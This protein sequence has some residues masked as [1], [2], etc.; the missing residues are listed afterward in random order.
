MLLFR[1]CIDGDARLLE[2]V[3]HFVENAVGEELFVDQECLHGVAGRGV[4]SLGVNNDPHGF[5]HVGSLK[6]TRAPLEMVPC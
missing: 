5:L 2:P 1:T 6:F 4:V 3:T